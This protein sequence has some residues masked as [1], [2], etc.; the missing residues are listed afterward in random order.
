[1]MR[2]EDQYVG[3][4]CRFEPTLKGLWSTS[5]SLFIEF[6][7]LFNHTLRA[8]LNRK[9][10]HMPA[11]SETARVPHS[12]VSDWIPPGRRDQVDVESPFISITIRFSS[13]LEICATDVS[14]AQR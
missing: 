5:D 11:I 4:K 14:L 7:Y 12:Y 8:N 9:V 1:M 13:D 6:G 3:G 2:K 10:Q